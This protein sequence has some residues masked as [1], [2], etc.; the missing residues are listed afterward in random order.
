[1]PH[2]A[3]VW[4]HLLGGKD[5]YPADCEAAEQLAWLWPG[6][7]DLA[8]GGRDFTHRVV[9]HLADAGVR[10]FLDIGCGLPTVG[11]THEIAQN[12]APD[13]RVVYLDNDPLVL[14][15]ARALLA[16]DPPGSVG[17]IQ[18]DLA[19]PQELVTAARQE[20]D[21][22]R[23]IAILL[24]GVLHHIANH[25]TSRHPDDD[26]D[27]GHD[28]ALAQAIVHDL[29]CAL[30]PRSYV[31][32]WDMTAGADPALDEAVQRHNQGGAAPWHLRTVP[33]LTRLLRGLQ[34]QA[35]GVVQLNHWRPDSLDPNPAPL[36]GGWGG[37]GHKPQAA[38]RAAKAG[39]A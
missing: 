4:N 7:I 31:A 19:S 5:T 29:I 16:C 30:P 15:H 12:S 8:R 34:I 25:P 26:H 1:M 2:S 21:F 27:A 22:T 3:R 17:Y 10:Q 18:A 20:L 24:M 6:I 39:P 36:V 38:S 9:Q 32:L 33:Q 23:P 11:S 13:A 35:P 14:A 28:D 37:V